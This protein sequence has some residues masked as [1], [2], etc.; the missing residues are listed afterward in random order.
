MYSVKGN[1]PILCS[2]YGTLCTVYTVMYIR[3]LFGSS[4]RAVI[5]TYQG[6]EV[7]TYLDLVA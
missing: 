6:K 1:V 4:L 7:G 3:N 2:T 5:L